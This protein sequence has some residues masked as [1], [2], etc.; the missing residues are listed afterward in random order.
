MTGEKGL[1]DPSSIS[2]A[3]F[4]L[5]VTKVFVGPSKKRKHASSLNLGSSLLRDQARHRW[6]NKERGSGRDSDPRAA[7]SYAS[8]AP[9]QGQPLEDLYPRARIVLSMSPSLQKPMTSTRGYFELISENMV[10]VAQ[11]SIG[12]SFG[13]MSDLLSFRCVYN[14]WSD[15][16][17][18]SNESS[19]PL[20]LQQDC[21]FDSN[22]QNF[23]TIRRDIAV[24]S[25][26][27]PEI[28]DVWCLD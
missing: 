25:R 19:T 1:A 16:L 17:I 3:C 26:S 21:S 24:K 7:Y 4:L 20:T 23:T 10:A 27:R 2:E 5:L 14:P 22:S 28:Q 9:L 6:A 12:T 13:F 15:G 11:S 18:F 8:P